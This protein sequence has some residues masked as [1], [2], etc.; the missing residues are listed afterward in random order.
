MRKRLRKIW[1]ILQRIAE[2]Q[3]IPDMPGIWEWRT[4]SPGAHILSGGV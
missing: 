2:A 3:I 1:M 4:A